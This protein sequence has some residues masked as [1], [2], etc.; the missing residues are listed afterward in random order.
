MRVSI[1]LAGGTQELA[2]VDP[3]R[4]A[5]FGFS[6]LFLGCYEDDVRWRAEE[7]AAFARRVRAHGLE[8]YATPWGYGKV[9]DPDPT[10]SSLYCDTHPQTLQLDSRGRRI[11]KACPNDPYFL[12]WFSSNMRTLAWLLEVDGFLWDEPS[13]H[14]SRGNWACRCEYCQRL[15]HASFGFDLPRDFNDKVVDFRE[16]SLV[17]FVLAAAAAVQSVDAKLQSLVMPAPAMPGTSVPGGTGNWGAL[18]ACSAC[19]VLSL[20]VPWQHN[21]VPLGQAIRELQTEGGK[22]TARYGKRHIL[23]IAASPSPR[24]RI[25]EALPLAVLADYGSLFDA[26]HFDR[27]ES[28]LRKVIAQVT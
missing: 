24:D 1:S 23:W 4:L 21:D 11:P 16:R 26:P 28:D 6:S 15:F 22:H 14:H 19:D 20:F 5:D 17:M 3:A 9:L 8:S 7:T 13:F 10:V 27:I 12:E 25:L 18:V 2:G